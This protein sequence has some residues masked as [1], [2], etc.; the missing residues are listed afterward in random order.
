LGPVELAEESAFYHCHGWA[1]AIKHGESA[2]HL[3]KTNQSRVIWILIF[4]PLLSV[5][6][7]F[8][9]VFVVLFFFGQGMLSCW[10]SNF[11]E[12][13]VPHTV[14]FVISGDQN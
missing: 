13:F 8:I 12:V 4:F 10:P 7:L 2:V 11:G 1:V 3:E 14:K 6:V 9:V 5:F